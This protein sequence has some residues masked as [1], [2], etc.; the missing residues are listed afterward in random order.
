MRA[1]AGFV[2]TSHSLVRLELA[3]RLLGFPRPFPLSSAA[4]GGG[5]HVPHCI[6]CPCP[7]PCPNL[8]LLPSLGLNLHLY[9]LHS[10]I[11][12]TTIHY[13]IWQFMNH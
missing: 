7:K 1:W 8:H 4:A 13:S 2:G 9:I 6:V 12:S 5:F 10:S 11:Y 3:D